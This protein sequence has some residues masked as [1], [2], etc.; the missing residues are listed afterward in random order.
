M[1]ELH[2]SVL[3][4]GS[5][6]NVTFASDGSSRLLLDAGLACREI[7]RRLGLL[8]IAPRDLHGV[9]LSHEHG[10]H[11]KGAWR[12]CGKHKIPLYAT[13]GTFRGVPRASNKEIDW[14]RVRSGS[15][16]KLGRLI[17]DL[18][19]TPHDAADPVGFRLRRGKLAFGHVTD[20]GHVSETVVD[21]LRGSTAILIESNHDVEML[22]ESDYP[23][24]LKDRVRSHVGHLSN[25]AL[26]LYLEYRLPDSVRHL[27]LAHLSLNNNHARLAL[28][29]CY[30]A[31]QR[32]GGFLPKVHLTYPDRPTPLLRL[33]EPKATTDSFAQR[34]L[35]F[36]TC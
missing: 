27:F 4:S 31:L 8:G 25:E 13:E 22:R 2:V 35:V 5:A 23:D 3:G 36:E 29:S 18:F 34:V 1:P 33:T 21:G 30:D 26:A 19:P 32:R 20:I 11:A 10:D 17:V 12:F 16:V 9:F 6:G 14:V 15:S 7:E 28:D 24:S